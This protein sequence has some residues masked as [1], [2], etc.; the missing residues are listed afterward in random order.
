MKKVVYI[1]LLAVPAAAMLLTVFLPLVN[2][3]ALWFG[4]PSVMVWS[5]IWV[6]LTTVVLALIEWGTHHRD[7]QREDAR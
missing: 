1:C 6:A 4:L 2:K 3:P 5:I 7:D